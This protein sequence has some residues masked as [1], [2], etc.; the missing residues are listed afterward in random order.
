VQRLNLPLEAAVLFIRKC[1]ICDGRFLY[2]GGVVEMNRTLAAHWFKPSA[3]QHN[4]KGQY[5]YAVKPL[6]LECFGL[7]H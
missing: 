5:C 2:H 3:S 6:Y 4:A 1:R 7:G